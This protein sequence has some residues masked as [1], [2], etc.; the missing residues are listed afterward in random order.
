[1]NWLNELKE[2][3]KLNSPNG[4]Y[5]YALWMKDERSFEKK[6][7]IFSPPKFNGEIVQ[8]LGV[9]ADIYPLTIYFDGPFHNQDAKDF[10]KACKEPGQWEVVHPVHGPLILQLVSC[11]EL[12]DPVGAGN[13]TA[14]NL[15]WMVPAN[16]E[17]RISP[18]EFVMAII[19]KAINAV[20]EAQI[21]LAQLKSDIYS[22]V[23]TSLNTFN[24]ISGGMDKFI[25]TAVSYEE[26]A[27]DAYLMAHASLN[28]FLS[29]YEIGN[30]DTIDIG[31]AIANMA[32]A[33][34][35][36]STDFG[37]RYNNFVDLIDEIFTDIPAT[38][39]TDD[40]NKITGIEFG[41]SIALMAI[42]QIT[43]TSVFASRTDVIS[44]MENIIAIFNSVVAK[45]EES[46][47]AFSG[48]DIDFQY[49]SQTA[50]YTGLVDLY[51]TAMQ[52]LIEQFYNLKIERRFRIKTPRSP[53]E[54]TV[55][56]Y[57]SL[58]ENDSNYDL[59]IKS[60]HLSGNDILLL[61]AGREVVI[62]G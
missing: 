50:T 4:Q 28:S 23:Q 24:K 8:D 45:L 18:A 3:V 62:Y 40:Y 16:L 60:N 52:Y 5:F 17:R 61:P 39:T 58:G 26:L 25:K 51:A 42:A 46:Q 35:N 47:E 1:M 59:F 6:L 13:Y 36:S 27:N 48:K 20:D 9:K 41:V 29:T 53:L 31:E 15:Q 19:S 54:I 33:G 14:F 30:T 56:E 49:F 43:A 32:I 37:S 57:G 10:F 22:A 38:T 11:K 34:V 55:T 44:A 12:D 7:G 21:I 2:E